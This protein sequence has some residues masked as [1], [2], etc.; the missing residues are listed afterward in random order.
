MQA[1]GSIWKYGVLGFRIRIKQRTKKNTE[2]DIGKPLELKSM[3]K[4]KP[5]I[6]DYL[7]V[8][9]PKEKLPHLHID[10]DLNSATFANPNA[11]FVRKDGIWEIEC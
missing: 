4:L 7:F 3:S 1:S 8:N 5:L 11:I 9:Y 10:T 6:C 2:I